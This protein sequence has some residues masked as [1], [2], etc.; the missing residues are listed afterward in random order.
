[1]NENSVEAKL[2]KR[3]KLLDKM[4]QYAEGTSKQSLEELYKSLTFM[5]AEVFNCINNNKIN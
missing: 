3:N 1:M 5:P 2:E 4:K